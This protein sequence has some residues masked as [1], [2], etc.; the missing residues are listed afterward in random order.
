VNTR[1]SDEKNDE[2][3]CFVDVSRGYGYG[4]SITGCAS[5]KPNTPSAF[6]YKIY[7]PF[8]AKEVGEGAIIPTI[9]AILNAVYNA[10][11][12]RIW[13]LPVTAERLFRAMNPE[14]NK[15]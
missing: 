2:Q 5:T 14:R 1:D 15:A 4:T 11:G 8:G 12:V 3:I 7:G 10:T 6:H 13:E 9:P